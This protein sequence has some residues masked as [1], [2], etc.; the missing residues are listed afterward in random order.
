MHP[1]PRNAE[2]SKEVD[3]DPRAAYFRQVSHR[4]ILFVRTTI[5]TRFADALRHVCP[6]GPP[7]P[8]HGTLGGSRRRRRRKSLPHSSVP[9][10]IAR[11]RPFDSLFFVVT[12]FF[13]NLRSAPR[14]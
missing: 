9:K 6:H 7:R 13:F 4:V 1:L 12:S 10:C 8:R 14:R 5:L 3:D 11:R 2:L